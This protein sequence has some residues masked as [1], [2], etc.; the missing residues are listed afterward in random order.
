MPPAPADKQY[1]GEHHNDLATA[2]AELRDL[3]NEPSPRGM[4]HHG[5]LGRMLS[6]KHRREKLIL[7]AD[8]LEA[9]EV[10]A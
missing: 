6:N 8:P 9:E 5:K 2:R 3:L 10:G 7:L 1:V 4:Q